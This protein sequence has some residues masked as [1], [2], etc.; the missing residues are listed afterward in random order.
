L[1]NLNEEALLEYAGVDGNNIKID[2]KEEG[3]DD[4]NSNEHLGFIIGGEF[5]E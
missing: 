1:G 2:F 5:I 4:V 3:Y